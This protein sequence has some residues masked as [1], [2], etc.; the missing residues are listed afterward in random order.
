[1]IFS[2]RGLFGLENIPGMLSLLAGKPAAETFPISSISINVKSQTPGGAETT[3]EINSEG[4]R[5][6]DA[7]QYGR[8][9]GHPYF[10][11]WLMELQTHLHKRSIDGDWKLSVGSGSQDLIYKAFLALTNPGD[12]V[13][14]EAP[15]YAGVIPI[16]VSAQANLVEVE[17]DGGGI[18]S[19]SLRSILENWPQGKPYPK[20]LYTV[21]V[22]DIFCHEEMYA[23]NVASSMDVIQ[24]VPRR[25]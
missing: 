19:A 21:P 20:Y 7:L 10:V 4:N 9:S 6:Y 2:V 23:L 22:C 24:L 12:S 8:T 15:V 13:L 14:I 17:T 3:L 11:K 25:V 5:L 18:Q 16:L 1:M